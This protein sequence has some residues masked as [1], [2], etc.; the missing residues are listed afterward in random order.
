MWEATL[1]LIVTVW[2]AHAAE[3]P[4]AREGQPLGAI[5]TRQGSSADQQQLAHE[6]ADWLAQVVGSPW[7]VNQDLAGGRVVLGLWQDW[8]DGLDPTLAP[9]DDPE[10]YRLYSDGQRVWILARSALGLQH[11][12]YGFLE[13]LGCRWF[14]PDPVWTVIP[15]RPDLAVTVDCRCQPAFRWRRIWY[16]WGPRSEKLREDY[17]AWLRHNRQLGAFGIDCGHA[18]ERYVPHREFEKH[19]EWFSLVE[20][21]RQPRQLCV[22][23]PEVQARVIAG[24]LELFERDPARNMVSV[25][26]NDGGGHCECDNC[27]AL[28]AVSDRVFFL[29][30]VVARAVRQR[31]PGK[32]VGLYAYAYHSTPPSL[33]LEPNVFVAVTTGFR[34]TELSLEQQVQKLRAQGAT[35]GVYDYFS[36]YPWDWDMPGAAKAGRVE[37]LAQAIRHYHQLG[38]ITYDAESS[39]NW[40]PNGPGYWMAA[41][42]MWQPDTDIQ[43]LIED[44]C[45]KAFGPAASPVQRLYRRWWR[46]ERFSARNL[47]L[48]LADLEEAYA[49]TDEP[50]I[51]ARLDRLA[52][53]LHWLRLWWEY[54]RS[55]R[56]NQWGKIVTAPPEEIL[57]RAQA[58]ITYTR[59]I[60]DTGLI[61]AYPALYSEWFRQRFAALGKLPDFDWQL[62]KKW[63]DDSSIP[64]REEV[65]TDFRADCQRLA[66]LPAVEIL[67]RSY[68]A[69]LLPVA[70]VAPRL[71]QAW[72]DVP[73][74]PVFVES[75]LFVL[76]S[77]GPEKLQLTFQPFD[78]G[79]TIDCRWQ[80]FSLAE[81]HNL[82]VV[83]QGH[84]QAEKGQS[85]DCLLEI[86]QAGLWALDP[87]TGYWRAAQIGWTHRPLVLWAGR[88]EPRRSLPPLRLW[89]PRWGQP[90]YF[91][92][93]KGTEHF[94]IAAPSGGDPYIALKVTTAAGQL[95]AEERLLAGEELCVRLPQELFRQQAATSTE[96]ASPSS[97]E[98]L[99]GQILSLEVAGLRCVL[100]LYD[101]PPYLARHPAEL[102]VPEELLR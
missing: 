2:P 70:E 51:R 21:K 90:L 89:L 64:T 17:Q 54:D 57:A 99:P 30:N 11:A 59:K 23:N 24:V 91:F 8:A 46:G 48:A 35:L 80:L 44:F 34:Y 81:D 50:A 28:G 19:P 62:P 41:R 85:A 96:D 78:R 61:H 6:L 45:N 86:P 75:A 49:R 42:L 22:S 72:K 98:N 29:A 83:S 16:G 40:G 97:A 5:V 7:E 37:E 68:S 76:P 27:R 66:P 14:F 93:P 4:L 102:L 3:T 20:G 71:V 9:G 39:C 33:P 82:Q 88:A 53:Y 18:Y 67:G 94:V 13:A 63:L 25:E 15:R 56:W 10:A 1:L 12:I 74:S 58:V 65:A 92:V 31:F 79:H 47:K 36:V 84:L 100:E 69:R 77:S 26:P 55:A 87:G 43:L 73:P 60:M 101:V 95:L 52:M 38:L 32:W